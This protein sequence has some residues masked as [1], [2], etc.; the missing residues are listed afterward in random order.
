MKKFLGYKGRSCW[1]SFW[2]INVYNNEF[3]FRNNVI[4]NVDVGKTVYIYNGK[5]FIEF[6]IRSIHVGYK[7][8]QFILTRQF[9]KPLNKKKIK[10]N[11]K[12]K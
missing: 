4:C 11:N 3:V 9:N 12:K 5:S 8:G 7:F 2:H 1:K 10:K 6:T